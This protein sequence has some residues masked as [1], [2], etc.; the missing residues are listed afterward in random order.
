MP[1]PCFLSVQKSNSRLF[2]IFSM[3]GSFTKLFINQQEQKAHI[4]KY[5][6]SQKQTEAKTSVHNLE[7]CLSWSNVSL[8]VVY[9]LSICSSLHCSI[10]VHT[11]VFQQQNSFLSWMN[12]SSDDSSRRTIPVQIWELLHTFKYF[13]WNLKILNYFFYIIFFWCGVFT[14]FFGIFKN[15]VIRF[16]HEKAIKDPK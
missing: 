3:D 16:N 5:K 8:Y 11:N 15:L 13:F 4:Y 14:I 6:Y 10:V 1:W 2:R 7:H 9:Y 12:R